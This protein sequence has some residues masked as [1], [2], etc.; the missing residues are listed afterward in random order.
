MKHLLIL[1][2]ILLSAVHVQAEEIT[3]V[4]FAAGY[5]LEI[6][7]AGPFHVLELPL[8]VYRTVRRS[9][10][11]DIRVFNGAGEVV[12]HALRNVTIGPEAVRQKQGIPFF[13]LHW[14]TMATG[15]ADLTML[16]TRNSVG[17]IVNINA[18]S[19]HNPEEAPI[20]EY[21][22]DLSGLKWPV[23]GLEFTWAASQD[24]SIFNISLQHSNDLQRWTPLVAT[25][26]LVDL[27]HGGERIEK[28]TVPLAYKPLRYLRL[29]RQGKG[30]SLHLTQVVGLSQIIPSLQRRQ[31]IDLANGSVQPGDKE[32]TVLYETSARLPAGSA[33]MIFR[34]KNPLARIALQSRADEKDPWRTRCEQV[35]YSLS[36]AAAE[37]RN[38]PCT[39]SPTSD[40]LWRALVREDGAGIGVR[41]Q[42][43]ILQLG[44][45]PNELLFVARGA[46]PYL[47]AFGSAKLEHQEGKGESEMIL[48]A[49]GT[50]QRSQGVVP[51]RLGKRIELAGEKA[52]QPIPPP[53]P[54]KK[55][56][57]WATLILG[58]GLLAS[59][60]RSLVKEM[61]KKEEKRTTEEP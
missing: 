51:A 39:F 58:V 56:L 32:L 37:V 38:E 61:K 17:T 13:P 34:D 33:Q 25:A 24:S 8:E 27:Q 60:A 29:T 10:L 28:R 57:L 54:W 48:Q 12:P 2:V 36:L 11:G 22:L 16:V 7:G 26:A 18:S 3:T 44:W 46:P 19:L 43:P 1:L 21:L 55:W 50:A 30:P 20:T 41:G 14:N 47:L 45:T 40:P 4:D 6:V 15:Q 5:Y 42:T 23:G 53:P 52:L 31:W 49:A 9:D 59:M 35:F